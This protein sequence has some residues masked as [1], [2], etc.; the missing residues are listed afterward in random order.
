MTSFV[1]ISF[2]VADGK[3]CAIATSAGY[4]V[5]DLQGLSTKTALSFLW[6]LAYTKE[7]GTLVMFDAAID[8]ELLLRD[9]TKLQKDILFGCY[10]KTE[11]DNRDLPIFDDHTPE[12]RGIAEALGFRLSQLAGKTFR[13][14]HG[15]Q[16]GLTIYDIS[17]YFMVEDIDVAAKRFLIDKSEALPV[18]EKNLLPLWS[19]GIAEALIARCIVEARLIQ[20]LA[21]KVESVVD[22]LNINLKQW[23]GPSAIA[24]RC[25]YKWKARRQAKIL[26]E[27]NT[28]SE[29]L[30]AIDCAYFGGRVEL[31]QLGTIKDVFTYDLNSAYAYACTLLAQFYKPLRF[32]RNYSGIEKSPFSCWLV[33]Y[34]LPSEVQLGVLPTRS[35]AGGISFRRRGKGYF[36]QPEVDYLI[37]HYPGCFAIQWGYEGPEYKPV[38]FAANIE[39]MYAYRNELKAQGDAGEKIIKLALANLYGKFAQN[40]GAAHFQCRSW[41][42]WLVS[43]VRR[44]LLDAV[45]GIEDRVIC[46]AQDAVHLQGATNQQLP[47]GNGLGE[48][49]SAHYASGLY[50]APGIYDLYD[51]GESVKTATRG[52]NLGLDF[53]RLASELSRNHV[54]SLE[55]TFFVGWQL[56]R[57]APVKYQNAYLAEVRER[58]DLVPANLRARHYTTWFDW[59]TEHRASEISSAFS[60]QLSAR[61]VPTNQQHLA[62]LRLRLRD[63][64]WR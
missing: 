1:G 18:I 12:Y 8:I 63:R 16:R 20:R 64:G 53:V 21:D 7:R 56:S 58:L 2:G 14:A 15:K 48:W 27:K 10:Q 39:S 38:T 59:T 3:L 13:L 44:L 24:A 23:Y 61:Y 47:V 30:K 52:G 37:R 6:S 11:N 45:T 22:P 62:S 49:K 35:P 25:L 9:L 43:F 36:W 54:T 31:L 40:T 51:E 60:G 34:E 26:H 4:G 5:A 41:A 17:S 50:V 55:R 28:A 42:G 57:Q 19:E 46:F 33:D 32:T 29:L